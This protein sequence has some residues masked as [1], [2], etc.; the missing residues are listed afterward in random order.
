MNGKGR[1]SEEDFMPEL[2]AGFCE[3]QAATGGR[4]CASFYF[5][6]DIDLHPVPWGKFSTAQ[7]QERVCPLHVFSLFYKCHCFSTLHA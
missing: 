3:G 1:K 2:P 5:G 6:D 4:P 7:V